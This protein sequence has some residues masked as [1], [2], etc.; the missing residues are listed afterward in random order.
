[1]KAAILDRPG[2]FDR[3]DRVKWATGDDPVKGDERFW[4]LG[5]PLVFLVD[6]VEQTV[7]T[8]FTTDGASIPR[9]G[10]ILTGWK[11]WD[12]PQRWPAVVHDWLYSQ[13]RVAKTYADLAFRALLDAEGAGWWMR[14]VMYLAVRYGGT[15][16]YLDDRAAGPMIY[17]G[18]R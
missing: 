5:G 18:D 8:G 9:F 12:E 11:R 6:G 14:T 3:V 2:T 16:A 7:P 4:I 15:E 1:V 13:P 17:G 10:Q